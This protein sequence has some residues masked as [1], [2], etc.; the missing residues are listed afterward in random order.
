V[1]QASLAEV[2][3]AACLP[4]PDKALVDSI[5]TITGFSAYNSRNEYVLGYYAT[6]GQRFDPPLRILRYDK[7]RKKWNAAQ[8]DRA[9]FVPSLPTLCLG[10]VMQVSRVGNFLYL[11]THLNPS[12]ACELVI[13]SELKLHRVLDGWNV[14]AFG[15]DSMVFESSMVH[16]APTHPMKL[17]LYDSSRDSVTPFYPPPHDPLRSDYME[18]LRKIPESDKCIEVERDC[19]RDVAQFESSIAWAPSLRLFDVNAITKSLAFA[20]DFD[21][22]GFLRESRNK[23]R[24][25]WKVRAVYVYRFSSGKAEYRQIIYRDLKTKFGTDEFGDLLKQPTLDHLFRELPEGH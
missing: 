2:I 12:A 16:F 18:R 10:S 20:V 13:T 22:I 14:S 19:A 23:D 7:A 3:A 4:L 25:D 17:S 21:P 15:A 24:S 9:T 8:V 1:A 5:Q 6:T 11:E